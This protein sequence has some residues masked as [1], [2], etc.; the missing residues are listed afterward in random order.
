[1]FLLGKNLAAT[2]PP[3]HYPCFMLAEATGTLSI[4]G[5][6]SLLPQEEFTQECTLVN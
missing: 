4:R 1:M 3:A 2:L 5:L 6:V